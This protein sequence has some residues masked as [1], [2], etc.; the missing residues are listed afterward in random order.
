MVW[1]FV[2][3]MIFEL[4][5]YLMFIESLNSG[6]KELFKKALIGIWSEDPETRKEEKLRFH[7]LYM[8]LHL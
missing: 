6:H 4:G 1:A 8:A 5:A 3:G 7:W 2:G